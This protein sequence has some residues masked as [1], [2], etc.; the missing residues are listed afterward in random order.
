MIDDRNVIGLSSKLQE[1]LY[2]STMQ[3]L[4]Q[5]L[6]SVAKKLKVV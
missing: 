5:L 6:K 4:Q 2:Q 3:K 1:K